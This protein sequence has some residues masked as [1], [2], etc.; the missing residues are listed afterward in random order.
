MTAAAP[1]RPSGGRRLVDSTPLR[2]VGLPAL[3][4]VACA[5]GLLALRAAGTRIGDPW[6]AVAALPTL[7]AMAA[8]AWAVQR[9]TWSREHAW[10]TGDGDP[11]GAMNRVTTWGLRVLLVVSAA[12][13]PLTW[14]E[15]VLRGR[16]TWLLVAAAAAALLWAFAQEAI[17][18]RWILD[19]A[20]FTALAPGWGRRTAAIIAASVAFS[21]LSPL[22]MLFGGASGGRVLLGVLSGA[23]VGVL[24]AVTYLTT[25]SFTTLVAWHAGVSYLS[26]APALNGFATAAIAAV[27]VQFAAVAVALGLAWWALAVRGPLKPEPPLV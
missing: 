17:I 26:F 24:A 16:F 1:I 10:P 13:A 18:R 27:V 5:A 15:A 19:H 22:V 7:A 21:A 6:L 9:G 11:R 14:F 12:I 25:P 2:V 8:A 3:F 23:V 4:G 20:L